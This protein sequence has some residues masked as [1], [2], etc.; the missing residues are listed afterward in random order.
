ME[1]GFLSLFVI[2]YSD[3]RIRD[4]I[5]RRYC[6]GL[7]KRIILIDLF[8]WFQFID[9]ISV[10]SKFVNFQDPSFL[11]YIVS[12]FIFFFFKVGESHCGI[13]NFD[14]LKVYLF[15]YR[16]FHQFKNKTKELEEFFIQNS[17]FKLDKSVKKYYLDILISTLINIF[18]ISLYIFLTFYSIDFIH[19]ILGEYT[20]LN[21]K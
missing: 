17:S 19:F 4:K 7:I 11:C 15:Y 20:I 14:I 9:E 2:N 16:I 3:N 5:I 21:K 8:L 1:R 6:D 12:K 18:L 10:F 13:K